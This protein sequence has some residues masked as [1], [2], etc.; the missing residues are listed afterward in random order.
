MA[1]SEVFRLGA[2]GLPGAREAFLYLHKPSPGLYKLPMQRENVGH[3]PHSPPVIPGRNAVMSVGP[4]SPCLS[5]MSEAEC[6][7]LYFLHLFLRLGRLCRPGRPWP[8]P[9][10]PASTHPSARIISTSH[11][12]WRMCLWKP[13]PFQFRFSSQA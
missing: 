10:P 3:S 11:D 8:L 9:S 1:F 4:P 12:T 5:P 7:F 2:S 6:G 13:V